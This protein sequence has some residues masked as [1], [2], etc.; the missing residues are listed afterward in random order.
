MAISTTTALAAL[1][2]VTGCTDATS[3][4]G[5][6]AQNKDTLTLGMTQDI[7]GWDPVNQPSYQGWGASAVYDSPFRCDALGKPHAA[8]AKTWTFKSD[9]TGVTFKLRPGMKFSDG[10]P[11]DSAAVQASIKYAATHGA[12]TA[13]FSGMKVSTPDDLTVVISTKANPLLTARLCDL[14]I[15]SPDYLASDNRNKAP[16]GSGPYTLDASA[17]TG[18]SVYTFVKND[19]YWDTK[20]FPYKKLVVKVITSETATINALKTGQIDGS[21]ITQATYSQAKASGLKI[22][23]QP[24]EVARLLL[25][26]HL[27]KKIPALGNVDVRR[28]M[29]MVFDKEAMAKNLF[30]GL[31]TPTAQ[32]FRPGSAAYVKDLK[33]PYPY[34]V[35][36]AKALMKKA[37][38]A[39]G[40]TLEIPYMQGQNLDSLMP[41]VKQQLGL[42][43]IKVKQV[44]LSGPN[45]ISELLS[46]KYPVPMWVLGNY[47]DSRLDIGDYIQPDGIWNVMHQSD[48]TVAKLWQ[49]ILTDDP[50]QT[51][52]DQQ[53]VNR[54]VVDQA[55]F[56][57]LVS[58][59]TIYAYSSKLDIPKVTDPSGLHPMLWDF[60]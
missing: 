57:P 10:T 54:Y 43:N 27:G 13:R 41:V 59:G 16:V 8:A 26:D 32:I 17:T 20:T 25:T 31:A 48:P 33:D 58:T 53:A 24:S 35:E 38:Y 7:Q 51:V 44:T 18:G 4:A 49:K 5:G 45:A 46:G 19:S 14:K 22:H 42:L 55:W 36:A 12:S 11:V 56:V 52:K 28:A 3:T 60:K 47:G 50:Q 39:N 30:R 40:F 1:V 29:N 2:A 9:N 15:A 34:D 23:T 21:L 6:A 37:G